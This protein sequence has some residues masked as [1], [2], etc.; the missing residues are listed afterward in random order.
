MRAPSI[1]A[2]AVAL[3]AGGCASGAGADSSAL[4]RVAESARR[5]GDV[6][7]AIVFYRQAALAAPSDPRPHVGMARTLLRSGDPS[8]AQQELDLARSLSA[9]DYDVQLVS[10][11]VALAKR[12]YRGAADALGRCVAMNARDPAALN[13]LGISLDHLGRHAEAKDQYRLA[14]AIDPSHAATRNNLALSLALSGDFPGAT[15]ML[16]D[17]A[18]TQTALPRYRQNLALVLALDGHSDEAAQVASL[19]LDPASARADV[20]LLGSMRGEFGGSAL[21]LAVLPSAG[22]VTSPAVPGGLDAQPH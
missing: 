1:A 8:G 3:L 22:G 13:M 19:D 7:D 17:L 20:S 5:S 10:G 14:L 6:A 9:S 2:L 4:A 15:A 21:P 18:R 12:D 11:Q 16:R